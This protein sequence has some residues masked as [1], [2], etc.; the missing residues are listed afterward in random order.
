MK[1]ILACCILILVTL[2]SGCTNNNT[3]DSVNM[4]MSLSAA[5]KNCDGEPGCIA[6]VNAAFYSGALQRGQDTTTGIIGAFVPWLHVGLEF[7]R[8][9][10]SGGDGVGGGFVLNRSSNNSFIIN[11]NSADRSSTLSAP[12]GNVQRY[13]YDNMYNGEAAAVK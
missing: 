2:V 8:I 7:A 12:Y 3:Q 6:T 4:L 1:T 13:S 11:K 10:Q 5:A 9:F